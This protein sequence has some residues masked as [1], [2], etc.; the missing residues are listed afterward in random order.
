MKHV[1]QYFFTCIFCLKLFFSTCH[2]VILSL[3]KE[4]P[5]RL[6][7]VGRLYLVIEDCVHRGLIKAE[8]S[9]PEPH[10]VDVHV[11][12]AHTELADVLVQR[13]SLKPH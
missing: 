10:V 1:P 9:L 6:P 11:G 12:G 3:V 7:E 5:V 13:I 4:N 2:T 8:V